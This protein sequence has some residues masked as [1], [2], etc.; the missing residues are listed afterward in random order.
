LGSS[1][2]QSIKGLAGLAC[3]AFDD[4]FDKVTTP[5]PEGKADEDDASFRSRSLSSLMAAQ[6]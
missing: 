5:W 3:R 2:I 6:R 1:S 4:P